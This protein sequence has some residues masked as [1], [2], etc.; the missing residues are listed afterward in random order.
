LN[1]TARLSFENINEAYTKYYLEGVK[2]NIDLIT[3]DG[4]QNKGLVD[5]FVNRPG[6]NMKRLVAH[7]DIVITKSMVEAVNK[8]I[9]YDFLFTTRL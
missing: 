2:P 9:K 8:R 3:D 4:S 6:G 7:S 1:Y 5:L